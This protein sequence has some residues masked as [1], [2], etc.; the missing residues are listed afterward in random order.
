VT[1]T[2]L[3]FGIDRLLLAGVRTG[4][5]VFA[6]RRRRCDTAASRPRWPGGRAGD[7]SAI[8]LSPA[9][10]SDRLERALSPILSSETVSARPVTTSIARASP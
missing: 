5:D 7:R 2:A 6:Q 1:A 4:P 10:Q 9:E 3:G 8:L